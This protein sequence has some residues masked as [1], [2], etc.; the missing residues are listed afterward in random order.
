VDF[1]GA[2]L[3]LRLLNSSTNL[4]RMTTVRV[5]FVASLQVFVVIFGCS[6][7]SKLP[8]TA[9]ITCRENANCPSDFRC[10]VQIGQCIP[11][12]TA[13]TQSPQVTLTLASVLARPT[14]SFATTLSANEPLRLLRLAFRPA[15]KIRSTL[16]EVNGDTLST[17]LSIDATA[18]DGVVRLL[19][20]AV[21]LAGNETVEF[22]VGAVTIDSTAPVIDRRVVPQLVKLNQEVL[23][24]LSLSEP[25]MP[26]VVVEF[27]GLDTTI[28]SA[29][30]LETSALLSFILRTPLMHP[31]RRFEIRLRNAVDLAGNPMSS[32][33]ERIG[34][35]TLD[36]AAPVVSIPVLPRNKFSE[37]PGF[38]TLSFQIQADDAQA[39][40][41]ACLV[42]VCVEKK[43]GE[44]VE[45]LVSRS[46]MPEGPGYLSL[47]GTD[48]AG[49][50]GSAVN[51]PVIFDYA[52]PKLLGQPVALV[53][54][55]TNCP[56]AP[57]R[58]GLGAQI[59]T[60]AILDERPENTTARTALPTSNTVSTTVNSNTVQLSFGP[61][62]PAHGNGFISFEILARDDVGN[63]GTIPLTLN[64]P[65]EIDTQAPAVLDTTGM[66]Y[67]RAPWGTA[68]GGVRFFVSTPAQT[69]LPGHTLRVLL[70]PST[71]SAEL[72]KAAESL[73]SHVE[74]PPIDRAQVF[75]S[76]LDEACNESTVSEVKN[77]SWVATSGAK[78]MGSS[79]GNPHVF[80]SVNDLDARQPV[81]EEL[82]S[83]QALAQNDA[84]TFSTPSGKPQWLAVQEISSV[85][86]GAS[87][88]DTARQKLVVVHV[89]YDFLRTGSPIEVF[90]FDGE[91]WE[92]FLVSGPTPRTGFSLG[93]DDK[94]RRVVLYGGR[95]TADFVPPNAFLTDTWEWDGRA[96]I[97]RPTV[98]NPGPRIDAQ[99]AF[100]SLAS[101]VVMF[102][103]KDSNN[104]F[105]NS[106]WAFNGSAWIERAASPSN[107]PAGRTRFSF[108]FDSI[109]NRMVLF[110]GANTAYLNDLWEFDGTN[111]LNIG[112]FLTKRLSS[113]TFDVGRNRTVV[114]SSD[115]DTVGPLREVHEWNGSAFT[116]LAPFPESDGP[117][118]VFYNPARAAIWAYDSGANGEAGRVAER[119]SNGIWNK[120]W[121]GPLR[122]SDPSPLR[123]NQSMS[124]DPRLQR[125][126]R[127]A[128][129]ISN[130]FLPLSAIE[131]FEHPGW[132]VL[133]AGVSSVPPRLNAGLFFDAVS[134]RLV[135]AGG[136]TNQ[137][138]Y[139]AQLVSDTSIF[140]NSGWTSLG[141][142]LARSYTAMTAFSGSG[143]RGISF[144][145]YL[146]LPDGGTDV[147]NELHEFN[148]TNWATKSLAVRPSPR[149]RTA[150]AYNSIANKLVI[151]GGVKPETEYRTET[152]NTD[153]WE[154]NGSVWTQIIGPGPSVRR[155][156]TMT[157]DSKRNK[158]VLYAG[159]NAQ[160]FL[161][162]TWEFDGTTWSDVS[163]SAGRPDLSGR[164]KH[165][166]AYDELNE[167][168]IVNGGIYPESM[169][170]VY[171]L[172]AGQRPGV[173]T[174][175]S[176][177]AADIGASI[178]TS[179]QI[180][181]RVGA[182]GF[183]GSSAAPGS[184]LSIR[185]QVKPNEINSHYVVATNSASA[186]LPSDLTHISIAPQ[187]LAQ[188]IVGPE[189]E[190]LFSLGPTGLSR[191]F[192]NAQASMQI[193]SVEV[194]VLYRRP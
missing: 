115:D 34:F 77:V 82:A 191:R 118:R 95:T 149:A 98:A 93:Y 172:R 13:D 189:Q 50:V 23:I 159:I 96:W 45:F 133:D 139:V 43:P 121:K 113:A 41:R 19:A 100:D 76:A 138:P 47:V 117:R 177:R 164:I 81:V 44:T 106:L 48:A 10:A 7:D 111:W 151:F 103:G 94:R 65:V 182:T 119:G 126:V 105:P 32:E 49:N 101:Q 83:P 144:S 120:L 168:I 156:A 24:Q 102:G 78:R 181:A 9:V 104:A 3:A 64:S 129:S 68:D 183:R 163:A 142:S 20:T 130:E 55:R 92:R 80:E 107:R 124:Y 97:E 185:K 171:G 37:Q 17:V 18:S 67:H 69:V 193:D 131:V 85:Q 58:A 162:D 127:A 180:S 161:N 143:V 91:S 136:T 170:L 56:I 26:G 110:G 30:T 190:I 84:L 152:I 53:S 109:R 66:T 157:Y 38:N 132:R 128:G 88:F 108:A 141:N 125:V 46:N 73:S 194:T 74:L 145:G 86:F 21:D 122:E 90:E 15:Q 79:V 42:N 116:T 36:G 27:I 160:G 35:V 174:R 4:L 12:N 112:S 6:F 16:N 166:M 25:V 178:V 8:N 179:I 89:P 154:Y 60:T 61:V 62:V 51:V 137:D 72:A 22:D 29:A 187:E 148:G 40:V 63:S 99:M 150:F 114:M 1:F 54:A 33:A 11:A 167:R 57:T 165:S 186:G 146:A 14:E 39:T 158:M 28:Q 175:I 59:S 155:D 71:S 52:A 153:T 184:E 188:M 31:D 75:V 87:C 169:T 140:G 134:Q 135:L 2:G 70:G 173:R 147:T 192:A 176:L 123:I 5:G